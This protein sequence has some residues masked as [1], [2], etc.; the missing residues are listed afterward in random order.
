MSLIDSLEFFVIV[1]EINRILIK[2]R[3]F[4]LSR[5]EIMSVYDFYQNGGFD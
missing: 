1:L 5:G 3:G 2:S 4:C